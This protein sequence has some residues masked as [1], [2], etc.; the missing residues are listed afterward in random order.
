MQ[1]LKLPSERRSSDKAN[2]VKGDV[3]PVKQKPVRTKFFN[4][5]SALLERVRIEFDIDSP[6]ALRPILLDGPTATLME[7]RSKTSRKAV[8][9][10]SATQYFLKEVPW[11]CDTPE[12]LEFSHA[13]QK[14][15]REAGAPIPEICE[16]RGHGT[17]LD[18][19]DRRLTLTRFVK[20]RRYNF[21]PLDAEA[22][23]K[24]LFAVHD[25]QD[26]SKLP[27]YHGDHFMDLA[28]DHISLVPLERPDVNANLSPTVIPAL[29]SITEDFGR[30]LTGGGFLELKTFV[31]HGDFNPWNISYTDAGSEVLAIFD[32]DNADRHPR[33]HDLAEALMTFSGVITYRTGSTRFEAV[34]HSIASDMA[35]A[36]LSG[37]GVSSLKEAEFLLL[38]YACGLIAVEFVCLGLLRGDFPPNSGQD[39]VRWV[40][41]LPGQVERWLA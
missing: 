39:L 24:A 28:R 17:W 3:L 13:F 27:M 15:L 4:F 7:V 8:I 5:N 14:Q 23:G 31:V 32:F 33:L 40:E 6:V 30:V 36:F 22:A 38:P 26:E 20:G 11:Y 41:D 35:R 9:A 12:F 34:S 1:G 29:Q 18:Y 10:T 2:E 21:T 19:D 37:Y 16:T 25:L